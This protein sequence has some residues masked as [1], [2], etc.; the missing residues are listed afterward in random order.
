MPDLNDMATFARVVEARSFSAAARGMNTSKSR[1]S[2]CVARLERA[3]GARLLN[4]STRRMS[5][6]E[7][8]EAF[9]GHCRRM[10]DEALRATQAVNHHLAAPHGVIKL[11]APPAFGTLRLAP[12]LPAFL[13]RHEQLRIDLSISPRT[14]DI[15]EGGY[16]LAIKVGREPQP[17]LAAR[18]LA[19]APRVICA[20]PGYLRSRGV[21]ARPE[22]LTRHNCLHTDA[23]WHL[24]GAALEVRGTLRADDERTLWQAALGELGIALLPTYM[25]EDDLRSGRLVSVLADH[26]PAEESLYALRMPGANVAPKVRALIDYLGERLGPAVEKPHDEDPGRGGRVEEWHRHGAARNVEMPLGYTV[27]PDRGVET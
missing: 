19:A 21:P 8:G 9:Y 22:D 17:N 24:R 23:T 6:T 11:S 15:I 13:A 20:A 26:P 5:L 16:D 1:V 10:L 27:A 7:A 18:R 14:P 2:K 4:R 12:V 3:L 25:V